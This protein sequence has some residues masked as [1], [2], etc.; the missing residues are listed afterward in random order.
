MFDARLEP[1]GEPA[2]LPAELVLHVGTAAQP[3]RVRPLGDPAGELVRITVPSSVPLQVGDRAILRDPG[4]QAVA[5][6]LLVLDPDPPALRRRGA[7]RARAAELAADDGTPDP[8]REVARRGAVRRSRLEALGVPLAGIPRGAVERAGWL[9]AGPRWAQWLEQA[10]AAVADWS[11]RNPLDPGMPDEAL[12]RALAVPDREL[13]APVVEAAG[14]VGR[15]GR[16]TA[17]APAVTLGAAE[18]SVR[19]VESRL[20][21]E[22]FAAPTRDELAELRLGRRELAAAERAGRLVRIADDVVL[23]PDVAARAAERLAGIDQP[24]TVSAARAALGT[25][26]RVA[27]PLL[28]YLDGQGVTERDGDVRRLRAIS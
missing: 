14:L 16:V 5:A 26:R 4:R 6:G 3:A 12:R 18:R 11:R 23:L 27:V 24:F 13:L 20:A 25:S 10:G 19:E 28:E 22:P 21:D 8:A 2:D 9:V 1:A 15:E 7:G 17:A